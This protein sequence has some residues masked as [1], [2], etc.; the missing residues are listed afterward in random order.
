MSFSV[1]FDWSQVPTDVTL[2]VNGK[3]I[4]AHKS[5]LCAASS[6]FRTMFNQTWDSDPNLPKD[7]IPWGKARYL[8]RFPLRSKQN[9]SGSGE[10]SGT[11]CR[12]GFYW[13]EESV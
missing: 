7:P 2:K 10:C 6:Y 9:L 11:P 5:L 4:A 3:V 12:C 8:H 1:V 13:N